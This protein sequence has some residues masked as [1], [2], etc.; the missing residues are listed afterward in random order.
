MKNAE[1]D[2][3]KMK[4]WINSDGKPVL[5]QSYTREFE[6]GRSNQFKFSKRNREKPRSQVRWTD[7]TPPSSALFCFLTWLDQQIKSSEWCVFIF[8]DQRQ[9]HRLHQHHNWFRWTQ[10]FTI[11]QLQP[12]LSTHLL[13]KDYGRTVRW[14]RT[15][16][17]LEHLW[18]PVPRLVPGLL[19]T[20]STVEYLLILSVVFYEEGITNGL[21]ISFGDNAEG[22]CDIAQLQGNAFA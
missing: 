4:K 2:V 6:S 21:L 20:A 10:R 17:V 14:G 8:R 19:R 18:S 5:R 22:W 12:V 13:S 16:V 9:E 7:P 15:E 3:I 11:P 1:S